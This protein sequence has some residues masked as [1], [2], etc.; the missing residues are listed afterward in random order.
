MPLILAESAPH[1]SRAIALAFLLALVALLAGLAFSPGH[2]HRRYGH[3]HLPR[4]GK[5]IY[6][7][8][9][10]VYITR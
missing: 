3:H 7:Q 8:A 4:I 1:R 2:H 6:T 5:C 9:G 10:Y